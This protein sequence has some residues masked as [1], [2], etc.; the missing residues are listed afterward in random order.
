MFRENPLHGLVR[1]WEALENVP[2]DIYLGVPQ[3]IQID[4]VLVSVGPASD[5]QV[6]QFR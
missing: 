4:D 5:I 6:G 3:V 2:A 1:I